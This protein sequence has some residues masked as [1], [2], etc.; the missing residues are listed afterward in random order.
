MKKVTNN[1]QKSL[2]VV[3]TR[4]SNSILNFFSNFPDLFHHLFLGDRSP[5]M[6][7]ITDKI[8]YCLF[9][10]TTFDYYINVPGNL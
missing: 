5:V 1:R 7:Q 8:K 6:F 10:L 2:A 3:A 9:L 4:I